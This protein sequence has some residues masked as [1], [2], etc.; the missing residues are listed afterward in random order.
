M[1]DDVR[2]PPIDENKD[3][4]GLEEQEKTTG[5]SSLSVFLGILQFVGT[6]FIL[7]VIIGMNILLFQGLFHVWLQKNDQDSYA[8]H[9]INGNLKMKTGDHQGAVFDFD[10][11]LEK[12][13]NKAEAFVLRA[14]AKGLLG[15][16]QGAINDYSKAI[17]IYPEY[18]GYYNDRRILKELNGDLE[19]ACADWKKAVDLGLLT[20]MRF[21]GLNLSSEL[22]EGRCQ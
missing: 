1:L 15:D 10:M 22:M 3:G 13:P 19:G 11:A 18:P 12:N 2:K 20:D 9:V 7:I 17:K 6:G 14:T 21:S 16:H 8:T 5:I 4:L